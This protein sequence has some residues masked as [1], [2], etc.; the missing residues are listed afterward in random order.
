MSIEEV[1]LNISRKIVNKKKTRIMFFIVFIIFSIITFI[2]LPEF[3]SLSKDSESASFALITMSVIVAVAGYSLL[4][5]FLPTTFNFHPKSVELIAVIDKALEMYLL[6]MRL[7]LFRYENSL[8]ALR[9]NKKMYKNVNRSEI[10]NEKI[11]KMEK[12]I[13]SINKHLE[14]INEKSDDIKVKTAELAWLVN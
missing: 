4:L 7:T 3:R 6:E 13:I 11:V 2:F 12:A 1:I 8:D 9:E 10:I 5:A 14:I